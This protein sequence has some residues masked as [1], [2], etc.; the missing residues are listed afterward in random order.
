V[1]TDPS[2]AA[3]ASAGRVAEPLAA[4]AA[5]AADA[6]KPIFKGTAKRPLAHKV[7]SNKTRPWR[8]TAKG[9]FFLAERG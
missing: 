7:K 4:L 8:V 5:L 9:V 6:T 1:V 3:I 2:T